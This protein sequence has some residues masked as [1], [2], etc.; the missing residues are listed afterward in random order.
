VNP[1]RG[2]GGDR[3][4]GVGG[5]VRVLIA[6]DKFKGTL[7]AIEA[8]EAIAAGVRAEWPDA[9]ITALPFADGGE[10]TVDAVIAVGG[11]RRTDVVQGPLGVPVDAQWAM[12][13]DTA[14]IE[15]AQSSGLHLVDP[16]PS[17]AR[18]AHTFGTGELITK[19][20]DASARRIVVGLGGSA[21]TD[22]GMG[23]LRA[24]GVR[25]ADAVGRG[26]AGSGDDLR[27][28]A[29]VDL[30]GLDPRI[31]EVELLLCSDVANPFAGPEGA[32]A[33]FGPQKGADAT[34]VA[35]LDE[36]LR[37]YAAALL[38]ATGVDLLDDG[39]GGSGGGI[40]GGLRAA[41][42]AV[43]RNGVDLMA[44]L[45]HLDDCLAESDLV[46]VGEGSLDSQSVMGK[47][48]V[49]V[50]RRARASGVPAIAVVGRNLLPSAQLLE[51]NIHAIVAGADLAPTPKASLA[52]PARW[53]SAAT[54]AALS[55]VA[56]ELVAS[57]AA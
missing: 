42:H 23:A 20:L 24:L 14:V 11:Q 37:V 33:V 49:G 7:S 36:G 31:L 25:V 29:S 48:P 54:R 5:G 2:G 56:S 10:G 53:V 9:M 13:G 41:C 39:W 6:P 57:G 44:D 51:E 18:R 30:D 46:I 26:R 15:M 55:R 38:V 19:A 47:T 28:V 43:A 17:S 8:A 34:A 32:A 45:L 22:G 40:G 3:A 21:T 50:A 12:I 27:R 1:G 4:G 52:E 35:D 16:S